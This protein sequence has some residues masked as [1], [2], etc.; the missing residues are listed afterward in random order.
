MVIAAGVDAGT[1]SYEIFAIEDGL[2][3]FRCEIKTVEVMKNPEVVLDAISESNAEIIAGISGYGLPIKRFSELTNEDIFLM[4]LSK[5]EKVAVGLR[6]LIELILKKDI[7]IYTIPGIIHLTTVPE[8]R[9]INRIDIGTPD[10]LCSVVMAME[11]LSEDQYYS[12]QS[13]VLVEAGYGFNA[14]IAVEGGK[15]VDGIGGTS[16]FPSYLS[17]GS[18]DAEIAHLLSSFPKSLIFRAG[19]RDYLRMKKMQNGFESL[20]GNVVEWMVEFMKKG[21]KAVEVSIKEN[22]RIVTSGRFFKNPGYR[23]MFEEAFEEYEIIDLGRDK[24]AEGAAV[25]ADGLAG[26]IFEKLVNI[27]EIRNA[28]G[29]VLDYITPEIRKHMK[30]QL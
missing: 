3:S 27:L 4:T 5:D 2:E 29:S 12:D 1:E 22:D 26:G 21:V 9:K 17:P 18:I 13:F 8:W 25:I 23:K 14:F 19:F 10:K 7:N 20:D 16:G 24:S 6:P 15:I 30:Y 28:R 11:R